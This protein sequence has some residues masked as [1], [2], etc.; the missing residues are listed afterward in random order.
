LQDFGFAGFYRLCGSSFRTYKNSGLAPIFAERRK[1]QRHTINRTARFQAD[2]GSI[3]HE[4]TITDIS[5]S[6]AQLFV[7]FQVPD[8]FALLISGAK[9][10]REDCQVVW[11]LGGKIGVT[12]VTTRRNKESL[13]TVKRLRVETQQVLRGNLPSA[14]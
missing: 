11:G 12:F 13:E 2:S 1:H 3:S 5:E 8:Q 10:T 9:L 14:R 7:G 4:C 6:G